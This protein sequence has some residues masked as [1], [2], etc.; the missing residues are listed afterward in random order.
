MK[1]PKM[2]VFDYGQTLVNEA[3]FDGVKG[4]EAVLTYASE[5]KHNLTAEQ[6]QREA[7]LTK[8]TQFIFSIFSLI[9]LTNFYWDFNLKKKGAY[10]KRFE[11][12]YIKS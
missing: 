12:P 1:K 5:N 3:E 10:E 7:H 9:G 2:I 8:G 11:K 4:T 6:I